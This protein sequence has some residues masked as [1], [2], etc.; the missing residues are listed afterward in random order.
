MKVLNPKRWKTEVPWVVLNLKRWKP[1][2]LWGILNSKRRKNNLKR[3]K[4][5]VP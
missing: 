3:M 2:A 5:E 4:T 1:E